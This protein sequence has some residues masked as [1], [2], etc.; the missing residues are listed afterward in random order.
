MPIKK[1]LALLLALLISAALFAACSDNEPAETA[2]PSETPSASP[3]PSEP[4]PPDFSETDFTGNWVVSKLT[5]S[6]GAEV[7]ESERKELKADFTMELLKDGLY[8]VYDTDSKV[9]GQGS[10]SVVLNKLTL[11]AGDKET[12]YEIKDKDT[13]VITAE[14]GSVTT[15]SRYGSEE[16]PA[17]TED[18][19]APEDTE[20][21]DAAD[22]AE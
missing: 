19:S 3:S 16:E 9:L 15:M 20:E 18:T 21:T 5:D 13:L 1:C 6:E 22:T 14:D 4:P 10:Y 12:V 7:G 11:T 17:D 2:P 8:F